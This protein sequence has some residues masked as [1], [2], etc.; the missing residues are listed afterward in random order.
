MNILTNVSTYLRPGSILAIMGSSECGKT[1]LLEALS[2]RKEGRISREIEF[3]GKTCFAKKTSESADAAQQ[4][5]NVFLDSMGFVQQFDQ[6]LPNLACAE[7]LLCTSLLVL[8]RDMGQEDR[9]AEEGS[10]VAGARWDCEHRKQP[11]WR[12]I[13]PG[14]HLG[15]TAASAVVGAGAAR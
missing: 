13:G 10:G 8:P 11:D 6:F 14:A 7:S 4:P 9:A 12:D 15:R 1:T 3:N 5:H 2:R